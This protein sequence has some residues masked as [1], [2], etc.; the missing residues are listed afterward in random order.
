MPGKILLWAAIS[1]EHGRQT[2][3]MVR[4]RAPVTSML[5]ELRVNRTVTRI[6][7]HWRTH[8]IPIS[9]SSAQ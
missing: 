6:V 2:Q 8:V 5:G 4:L 1:P 3:A 9:G 7:T